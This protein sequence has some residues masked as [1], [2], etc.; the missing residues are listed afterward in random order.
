MKRLTTLIALP[1][2]VL[3]IALVAAGPAQAA[4]APNLTRSTARTAMVSALK[5]NFG[6]SSI[7]AA[8]AFQVKC[9]KRVARNR[10]KCTRISWSIGDVAYKGFGKVKARRVGGGNVY[11][12]AWYRLVKTNFYCVDT[13]GKN[14]RDVVI[15]KSPP[16]SSPPFSLSRAACRTATQNIT[17]R[18]NVSCQRAKKVVGKAYRSGK[19]VPECKGRDAVIRVAGWKF[20]A[21]DN[22]GII[23]RVTKGNMRF[24]LSGGGAC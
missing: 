12:A 9:G 20:K 14:C 23:V 5:L 21:I 1:L 7:D 11:P 24:I 6:G 16:P 17:K 22:R 3:T 4:K 8:N 2:A 18:K 13:G 10:I 19:K 15:G